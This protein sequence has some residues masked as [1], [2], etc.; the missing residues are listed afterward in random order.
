MG[1]NAR[2]GE[3]SASR[4][5]CRGSRETLFTRQELSHHLS[6]PDPKLIMEGREYENI[7]PR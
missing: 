4:S 6:S 5:G 2:E 1:S 7:H 3:I